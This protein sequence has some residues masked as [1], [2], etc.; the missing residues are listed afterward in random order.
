M[1]AELD[2]WEEAHPYT[3]PQP[4]L[5]GLTSRDYNNNEI[6]IKDYEARYARYAERCK[7]K[8]QAQAD[9][10]MEDTMRC[11]PQYLDKNSPLHVK[12]K[13]LWDKIKDDP[14]NPLCKNPD[15]TFILYEMA[16]N[17]LGIKPVMSRED[18][19]KK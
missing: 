17:I 2:R 14:E 6:T 18:L 4:P 1:F 15:N 13:E 8:T 5:L 9:K 12:A 3:P 10:S 19:N 11:Y 16:A 7:K